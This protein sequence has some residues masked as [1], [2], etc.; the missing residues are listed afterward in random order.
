MDKIKVK[1]KTLYKGSKKEG[2]K[3]YKTVK[4]LTAAGE[5]VTIQ[6]T[7]YKRGTK[8]GNS[9]DTKSITKI[10]GNTK[11]MTHLG[12]DLSGKKPN[13][14]QKVIVKKYKR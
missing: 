14:L 13:Q 3:K 9:T 11:G 2:D 5:E 1:G 10:T 8:V 12:G 4:K 6:T 7:K